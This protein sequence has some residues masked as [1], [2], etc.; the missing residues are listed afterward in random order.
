MTTISVSQ[1]RALAEQHARAE[2]GEFAYAAG[3]V[4]KEAYLEAEHCWM[5]FMSEA[6][7]RP[8]DAEPASKR[9]HVVS[10]QG[11]YA[12]VKDCSDNPQELEACLA[13]MSDY[14]RDLP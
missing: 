3:G 12:A 13:K 2:L 9:A 1:A 11:S 6:V 14:F 8:A 10:R 5:F 4:L 7:D